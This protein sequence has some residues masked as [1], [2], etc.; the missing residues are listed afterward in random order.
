MATTF[1]FI[2]SDVDNPTI[3]ADGNLIAFEGPDSGSSWRQIFVEDMQTSAR[4]LVSQTAAGDVANQASTIGAISAD[5]SSVSFESEATNL[6]T[7]ASSGASEIYVKNLQTGA[8]A[9]A[10]QTG[11]GIVADNTSQGGALSADGATVA[12]ASNADNLGL[13]VAAGA[14]GVYV[15]NVQT[16]AL[17]LASQTSGGVVGDGA[18]PSSSAIS[19][20]GDVASFISDATNLGSTSGVEEVYVKT[21]SSGALA[22]A[23]ETSDGTL[24]NDNSYSNSISADGSKVAFDSNATNLAPGATSGGDE[25]Y[26]K[27]LATG[28][29]T[30]ASAAA[31]GAVA[32]G[33]S[34]QP[35]ISADGNYVIFSSD[36]TNLSPAATDGG[37]QVYVK[38]LNTGAIG[39]LSQTAGGVAGDNASQTAAA[40]G[41]AF[42]ADDSQVVFQTSAQNLDGEASSA[43]DIARATTADAAISFDPV[44]NDGIVNAAEAAAPV[45]FSGESDSV[46]AVVQIALD[47][48]GNP[49]GT[50]T[51][52]ADGHWA[53]TADVSGLSDGAH[54]EIATTQY[55]YL[56]PTT[57]SQAFL[58]DMTAPTVEFSPP[59]AFGGPHWMKLAGTAFDSLSGVAGVE[60]F[61]NGA[62][63]G[64]ATLRSDGAWT[65][66]DAQLPFGEHNFS[67]VATD[68]AGN[69]SAEIPSF[70][71][72][73]TGV[74]GQ[75]YVDDEEEFD[76]SGNLTGEYFT[77]RSGAVYLADTVTNLPNGN[78]DV[79]YSAGTYFNTQSFYNQDDLYG[80]QYALKVETLYNDDGTTSVTGFMNG[81]TLKSVRDDIMT[82]GGS[83]ETFS[84]AP[85]FG[86]D[87]IADF[88]VHGPGH[89]FI[90]LST[91]DFASVGQVLNHTWNVDGNAVI[92]IG[93]RQ[94]ITLEN[95]DAAELRANPQDFKLH[96]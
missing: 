75:P 55:S 62:D 37:I 11:A 35:I 18:S 57:A 39:L 90:S 80:P 14:W 43:P 19:A 8:L 52:G 73:Q 45:T 33:D 3:S 38:N 47:S 71:T 65:F 82:G 76:S 28:A 59:V 94:T 20:N 84:F 95:V 66:T 34:F 7:G 78:I 61:D 15:E 53:L 89:D 26:V 9:L 30:L 36:A 31:D 21:V 77:K 56:P 79:D 6:A 88:Q 12:F 67:A 58:V 2:P 16:G 70:L 27:N 86:Q 64:A 17:T 96:G 74:R 81:V 32:D 1:D 51:V 83:R 41:Q 85:H 87:E 40:S 25:V 46:G 44:A 68:A 49:V 54:T 50:A 48:A 23:S 22:I 5:G 60:I 91:Q 93:L 29:L 24:A 69:A 10:S 72:L 4:T 13:G 42:S 63:L 92:H